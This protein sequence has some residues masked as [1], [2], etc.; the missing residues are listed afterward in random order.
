MWRGGNIARTQEVQLP[1]SRWDRGKERCG[2]ER[3]TG[4]VAR[5]TGRAGNGKRNLLQP[6]PQLLCLGEN[7][8]TGTAR[9]N[10][11][12]ARAELAA[13][14]ARGVALLTHFFWGGGGE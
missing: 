11:R 5:G 9:G 4:V 2:N 6:L 8:G 13:G 3:E 12:P 1:P 7:S 10:A 14:R